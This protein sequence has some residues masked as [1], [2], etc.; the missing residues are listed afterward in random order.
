MKREIT[1]KPVLNGFIVT[2][3]CQT[4]V[5][6]ELAVAL[7]EVDR[8]YADPVGVEKSYRETAVNRDLLNGQP[9]SGTGLLAVGSASGNTVFVNSAPVAA[10]IPRT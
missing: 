6:N 2:C 7:T 4:L 9:P 5:F 8:Y 10:T 1:I 3:G